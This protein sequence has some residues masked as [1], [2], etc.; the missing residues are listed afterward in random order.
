VGSNS[1]IGLPSGSSSWISKSGG[2]P[3]RREIHAHDAVPSC[4][5]FLG[6]TGKAI[7]STGDGHV[8]EPCRGEHI[9]ELCF[10][11]SASDSTGPEIDVAQ[12]RVGENFADDD[13]GDLR[14][15]TWLE[16]TGDFS[17]CPLLFRHQIQD[18]VR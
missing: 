16:D 1:S 6:G 11:Q 13:V 9:D 17:D 3:H 14:A 12:R 7:E 8:A 10:Q 18:P 4:R 2:E 5:A 15:S